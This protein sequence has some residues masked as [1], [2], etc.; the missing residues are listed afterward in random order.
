M[1]STAL[2]SIFPLTDEYSLD[3]KKKIFKIIHAPEG[4]GAFSSSMLKCLNCDSTSTP[5]PSCPLLK[6]PFGGFSGLGI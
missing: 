6:S 1:L 3:L 4:V 2:L 5:L